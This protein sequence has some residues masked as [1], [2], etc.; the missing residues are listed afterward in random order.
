MKAED[1]IL[2]I[3]DDEDWQTIIRTRVHESFNIIC[4]TAVNFQ[5]SIKIIN[6]APPLALILDLNLGN[7]KFDESRWEGWRLAELAKDKRIPIIVITAFPRDDRIARA[8]KDYKVVDFFD[9]KN[10]AD[11]VPDF[12]EDLEK[13]FK[14]TSK[15]NFNQKATS[16]IKKKGIKRK[17]V[18][19]SYSRKNRIWLEKFTSNLKVLEDKNLLYVWNDTK[20]KSGA[21]WKDELEN[22]LSNAKVALL[23]VT[24]DF[25][26]SEFIKN[27]EL[28]KIFNAA[29][30]NG[31]IIFWVAV[32][33][34]LYEETYISEYQSANDPSK[35]LVKLSPAKASEEI[36]RICKEIMKAIK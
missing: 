9:K 32:M 28:P 31:L 18:F 24:P 26:A 30:K 23:L 34:S 6:S 12:I 11:R 25:L 36:V 15:R 2:I 13:I 7:N 27:V 5:S 14:K 1:Y 16:S 3:E 8:F 10:L 33:P 4:K 19:I 20:V 29:E 17:T 35:P 22:A 21:K